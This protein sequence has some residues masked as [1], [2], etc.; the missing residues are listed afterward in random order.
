MKKKAIKEI[1]KA[2]LFFQD[3]VPLL[4]K[5]LISFLRFLR[6]QFY[7]RPLFKIAKLKS[8][9][10][11]PNKIYWV[12]PDEIELKYDHEKKRID[13]IK[14]RGK[15]LGGDWDI[16]NKKFEDGSIYKSLKAH[17]LGDKK[18]KET[19]LYQKMAKKIEKGELI[20][21]CHNLKSLDN[22]FSGIDRLYKKI[23]TE[24]YKLNRESMRNGKC[25]PYFEKYDEVIV[26][27]SRK[28]WPLFCDGRHRLSIAKLLGIE[29][30]PVIVAARHKEWFNFKIELKKYSE[31]RNGLYQP[32]YHFDLVDIPYN[33]DGARFEIIKENIGI[34]NGEVLDIGANFGYFCHKLEEIGFEC[35]AIEINPQEVYFMKKLKEANRDNFS[36]YRESIFEF[37]RDKKLNYDVV[38]AL[39]VFHHFLKRKATYKQLIELLKRME[40]K[41]IYLGTPSPD[42]D[43][44][45]DAYRNYA[46][47]QFAE[48][49]IEYSTL[50]NFQLLKEFESGRRL[51]KIAQ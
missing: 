19:E 47:N 34:S 8:E 33:Y 38:L 44:M 27:I 25:D 18:W 41:E 39:Y 24:G 50:N 5:P 29:E 31:K 30:I 1:K 3:R 36:I 22:Y 16:S 17:F 42:E 12:D 37:K 7:Y 13:E 40:S 20:Q 48:F 35:T 43:Q 11:E 9:V 51:Y 21:G 45:K 32:A 10:E 46:P 28:G 6:F 23:K 15:I 26:N 2:F 4:G 49:I 14:D